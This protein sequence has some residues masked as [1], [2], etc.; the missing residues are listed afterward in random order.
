VIRAF[1]AIGIPERLQTVL[2]RV[3]RELTRDLSPRSVRWIK[4]QNIHLTLRF[5][6]DVQLDKLAYIK[7]GIDEVVVRSAPLTLYLDTI[8]CFPNARRPRI[9]WIGLAGDLDQLSALHRS[10]EQMLDSIGWEPERRKFHPHLTLG[11]VRDPRV[12]ADA[13]LPW[14]RMLAQGQLIVE[15]VHLVESQLFPTGAIYSIRHS[16]ALDNTR[17]IVDGRQTRNSD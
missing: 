8:G 10:I 5:L 6:G 16:G 1:I 3:S 15:T 12:V 2:G 7:R 14:G 13:S 11:R 9:I 17:G 4:P